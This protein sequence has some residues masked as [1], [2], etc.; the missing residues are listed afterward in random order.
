M[1]MAYSP[2]ENRQ[3]VSIVSRAMATKYI[4]M[5]KAKP[6]E[7]VPIVL[8][9]VPVDPSLLERA[10]WWFDI[11]WYGLL[12]T[13]AATAIAACATVTFLFI[14]F[15]S[16]NIRER[17]SEWRTSTLEVQAKRAD[18]DLARAKADIANADARAA[19]ATQKANEADVARLRLETKLA[20]RSLNVAEQAIVREQLGAYAG[21]RIDIIAFSQGATP[22]TPL[23]AIE[24]TKILA[25][26]GWHPKAWTAMTGNTV[27]TGI[28]ISIREGSSPEIEAAANAI[29]SALRA[30]GI[31]AS[32]YDPLNF[33]TDALQEVPASGV[34]GPSWDTNDVAPIRMLIGI[35][36]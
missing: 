6:L 27:V 8:Q 11:S 33:K 15:W 14:Q 4:A 10:D 32:R 9:S 1:S 2:K 34:N 35:K 26:S 19:E 7:T 3:N 13:G 18:A 16:S 36:P 30:E 23:L 5:G 12:W 28:P 21:T 31:D 29:V 25:E 17:Q 20:P 24:L 22:D